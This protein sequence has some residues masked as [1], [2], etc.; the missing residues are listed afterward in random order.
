MSS[1]V[2][3]DNSG[4]NKRHFYCHPTKKGRHFVIPPFVIELMLLN[5]A[6]VPK[7]TEM[8]GIVCDF[9]A[10]FKASLLNERG[11]ANVE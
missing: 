11:G 2:A 7:S 1:S 3:C 9:A 5:A 10:F 8:G 6:G 4:H